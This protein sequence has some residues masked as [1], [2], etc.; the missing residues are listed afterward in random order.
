YKSMLT[1]DDQFNL[2]D[3]ETHW[4]LR[5]KNADMS[6]FFMVLPNP[7]SHDCC[8]Y[9]SMPTIIIFQDK[10]SFEIFINP[11]FDIWRW[12]NWKMIGYRLSE[13]NKY[14]SFRI[15]LNPFENK[16]Q[17]RKQ[18]SKKELDTFLFLEKL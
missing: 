1:G 6:E 8:V 16:L 10:T 17:K 15:Y 11:K 2:W 7:T 3:K 5:L 12:E 14:N 13:D 4:Y 18:L 9:A